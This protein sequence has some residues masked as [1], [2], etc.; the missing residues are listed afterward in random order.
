MI[1]IIDYSAGNL[2]SVQKAI[3][4]IGAQAIITSSAAD[5]QR[6][7]KV[8]FPGVG[9]FGR[10]REEIDRLGLVEPIRQSIASGKPF[11]GICLG[12]QLLFESSQES[13]GTSGLGLLAG[14]VVRFPDTIKVPH[15]GWNILE[16]QQQNPL[17]SGLPNDAYFYFAHSYYISPSD[18]AIVIG[19][20]DYGFSYPV[21]IKKDQLYGLQ[22]HPEKSQKWGL[23][24]L[25]NFIE[26]KG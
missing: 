3:E 4:A 24:V 25:K 2:Y 8:I 20:S 16:Q 11:L 14:S 13:P 23:T 1:A 9:S 19:T 7:E 18:M 17:W 21:A 12:L 26:L 10:A 6:A 5:I 15:L 22:F